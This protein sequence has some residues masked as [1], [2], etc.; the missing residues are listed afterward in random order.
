M[1][2]KVNRAVL[3]D[4]K[5]RGDTRLIQRIKSNENT[6]IEVLEEIVKVE[7]V[8]KVNDYGLKIGTVKLLTTCNGEVIEF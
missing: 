2:R 8:D 7:E 6:N 4:A 3:K 5:R 1:I